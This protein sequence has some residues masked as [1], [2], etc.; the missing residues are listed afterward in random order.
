MNWVT[1]ITV[2][3]P[4]T[5]NNSLIHNWNMKINGNVPFNGPILLETVIWSILRI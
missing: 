1:I 3:R 5:G 2:L 4:F